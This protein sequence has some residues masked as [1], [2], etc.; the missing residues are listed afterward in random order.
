MREEDLETAV[1]TREFEDFG[2]RG[3]HR[4]KILDGLTKWHG[5]LSVVELNNNTED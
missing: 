1:T 2:D 4:E 3:C 5:R